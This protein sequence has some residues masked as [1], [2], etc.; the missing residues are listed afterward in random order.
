MSPQSYPF[1]LLRRPLLSKDVLYQFHRTT[2]E[3]PSAF[4]PMLL[5]IFSDPLLLEALQLASVQ[6]YD[7]TLEVLQTGTVSGKHKLLVTLY[8]YLIRLCCRCTPFG[9]FAGYFP[10]TF[11]SKTDI[12]FSKQALQRHRKLDHRILGAIKNL[13]LKNPRYVK[14]L[15]FYPNTSLYKLGDTFRYVQRLQENHAADFSLNQVVA[16][17]VLDE[18]LKK[19]KNGL[20]LSDLMA[21]LIDANLSKANA[22]AYLKSLVESQLLISEIELN[23]TGPD[24]LRSLIANTARLDGGKTLFRKLRKIEKDLAGNRTCKNIDQQLDQL[25]PNQANVPSIQTDLHFRTQS[26]ALN[27]KTIDYLSETIAKMQQLCKAGQNKDLSVF[28]RDLNERYGQRRVPLSTALDYDYGIGYGRL[29]NQSQGTGL[30]LAGLD[31]HGSA[32]ATSD[33]TEPLAEAVYLDSI[34]QNAY[35]VQLTDQILNLNKEASVSLPE[36]FYLLGSIIT[37]S[38]QALD[39]ADFLFELKA[40]CGPSASHL[41]TRFSLT[42]PSLRKQIVSI[43]KTE[44]MLRPQ[45][46]FAEIAHIADLKDANVTARAAFRDFE[47]SYLAASSAQHHLGLCDLTVSSDDGKKLSLY[48]TKYQKEVV[49]VLSCAHNY[50][51]GLPIYRFLCELASQHSPA[52]Y[53]DWGRFSNSSFLP[54]V[55]YEK[56]VLSKASWLLGPRELA[57]LR[58]LPKKNP[59]STHEPLRLWWKDIKDKGKLPRYF[60]VGS[61]DNQLL[62]DSENPISLTLLSQMLKKAG[63]LRLTENL[64]EPFEGLLRDKGKYFSSEIIIPFAYHKN[65]VSSSALPKP[66]L[67]NL[68]RAFMLTSSWLYVKIYCSQ[69]LSDQIIT[70]QL[71][72]LSE[73][74]VGSKAIEKWFYI[75]YQDPKPHIRLR[76]YHPNK[77][78]FW[79]QVLQELDLAIAPLVQNGAVSGMQTDIY[80]RE[81]ERYG[82]RYYE[83]VESLFHLDSQTVCQCLYLVSS[84]SNPDLSWL[85][86]IQGTDALLSAMGLDLHK[87]YELTGAL[88]Q[89]LY[90]EQDTQG[91]LRITINRNYRL[92]KNEI[93]N[94]LAQTAPQPHIAPFRDLFEGRSAKIK[95]ILAPILEQDPQF[96]EQITPHLIHLFLNRWFS[97]LQRQQEL[98]VY[99]Y[100]KNYYV[101]LLKKSDSSKKPP[102]NGF[103]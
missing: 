47:I 35:C 10:V 68:T 71:W 74:L 93:A 42:D 54:R 67:E 11:C 20:L 31:F 98:V 94:T 88:A 16:H 7:A 22:R 46:I 49:P 78:D 90:N 18:L 58:T 41:L 48:S 56:L 89:Q 12:E 2:A 76:F 87:K 6:L 5:A 25:V 86:A 27:Q 9:L 28:A 26:A 36:S 24:Y 101:T 92:R 84:Q 85:A 77:A 80:Q 59:V 17:P 81:P 40:L 60:T 38:Q 95:A 73:K 55:Q 13:I 50:S 64:E 51:G 14:Q 32:Q 15:I 30:L 21:S 3:D 34:A 53:W 97:S 61:Y 57:A 100:L 23:I 29:K 65:P 72:P 8:K 39:C 33:A 82:A 96:S 63:S 62:I 102:E 1:A 4:G 69:A 44:E 19:T 66:D 75:R 91:G 45:V 70:D 37:A 52:L 79:V 103:M 99:H 43:I 83:Q